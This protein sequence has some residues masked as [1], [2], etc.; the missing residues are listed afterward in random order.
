M[1]G[2][3]PQ[4]CVATPVRATHLARMHLLALPAP[5]PPAL[6]PPP[7]H[8]LAHPPTHPP[9]LSAGAE[10]AEG[11]PAR[12]AV[13]RGGPPAH[14]ARHHQL[15]GGRHH[16]AAIAAAAVGA[17]GSPS[18]SALP[19]AAGCQLRQQGGLAALGTLCGA[20]ALR[21]VRP[22]WGRAASGRGR[23]WSATGGAAAAAGITSLIPMLKPMCMA[24]MACAAGEPPPPPASCPAVY[25]CL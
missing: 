8:V 16:A 18:G 9:V 13:A 22:A 11:H 15:A 10:A 12:A 3:G 14:P 2:A 5:P 24:C 6:Q 21:H 7:T 25:Y 19:V 17:P 20:G 23:C 1:Q 4:L